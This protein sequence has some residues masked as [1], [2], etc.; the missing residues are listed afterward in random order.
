MFLYTGHITPYSTDVTPY[1]NSHHDTRASF[2][3]YIPHP[4]QK[5]S[6]DCHFV[7]YIDCQQGDNM[8]TKEFKIL[9]PWAVTA[10]AVNQT[11]NYHSVRY[12]A[13]RKLMR[14]NQPPSIQIHTT[15]GIFV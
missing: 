3:C 14:S 1:T 11:I 12:Q 13:P 6:P 4:D 2:P 15:V 5:Q 7:T 10:P 8:L 9:V